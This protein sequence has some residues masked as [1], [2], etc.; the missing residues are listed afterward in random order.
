MEQITQNDSEA[1][2]NKTCR[3][4]DQSLP[5]TQFRI[6][7]D[8]DCYYPDSHCIACRRGKDNQQRLIRMGRAPAAEV[9][10]IDRSYT[11][12]ADFLLMGAADRS[13]ALV[14]SVGTVVWPEYERRAA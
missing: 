10:L 11:P 13:V 9:A 5:L 14:G 3:C 2:G 8:K 4:C 7:G 1:T 6:R 12:P